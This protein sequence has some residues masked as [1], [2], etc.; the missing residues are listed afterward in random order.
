M[1]RSPQEGIGPAPRRNPASRSVSDL[2]SE[3][4]LR[5]SVGQGSGHQPTGDGGAM[6][7]FSSQAERIPRFLAEFKG[8]H[9]CLWL[10]SSLLGGSK[11]S[12]SLLPLPV[13][14]SLPASRSQPWGR[15]KP[16]W[17]PGQAPPRQRHNRGI[18]CSLQA[19]RH[20]PQRLECRR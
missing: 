17:A 8:V 2:R 20:P 11:S 12:L 1:C 13:Q 3:W 5:P 4:S 19:C 10:G 7:G 14:P 16:S 18:L 9:H 15:G 6:A